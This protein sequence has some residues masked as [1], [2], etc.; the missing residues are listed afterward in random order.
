MQ[1]RPFFRCSPS[2]CQCS[3]GLVCSA[4]V[5][6]NASNTTIKWYRQGVQ[7]LNIVTVDS[8]ITVKREAQNYIVSHLTVKDIQQEE[9][10]SYYWCKIEDSDYPGTIANSNRLQLLEANKNSTCSR[11]E[12]C[13]WSNY[14]CA[15]ALFANNKTGMDSDQSAYHSGG[16]MAIIISSIGT[17]LSIILCCCVSA[18]YCCCSRMHKAGNRSKC[19]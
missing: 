12:L 14:S 5:P 2:A 4:V 9:M 6:I 15:V 3:F 13:S 7:S 11:Y 19:L 8:H 17:T 10:F 1:P 18:I 16:S